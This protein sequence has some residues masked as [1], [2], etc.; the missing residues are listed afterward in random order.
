MSTT[1]KDIID[2]ATFL[3]LESKGEFQK[4]SVRKIAQ[5]ANVGIGLINYHFKSKDKLLD[6]CVQNIVNR[7]ISGFK[8]SKKG[9]S[10]RESLYIVGKD[11]ADYL[12]DNKNVSKISIISDFKNPKLDDN[13]MKTV[14]GIDFVYGKGTD[15]F[16]SFLLASALQAVF[17]KSDVVKSLGYD[18]ENKQVR[19]KLIEYLVDKLIFGGSDES[20]NH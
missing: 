12:W 7:H 1:E 6:I 3:L 13:T 4:V 15:S 18:T 2:A 10:V 17:L 16:N 8:P 19:D 14:A 9:Q 11:V 5:R 20:D